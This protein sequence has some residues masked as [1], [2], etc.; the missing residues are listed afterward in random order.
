MIA[1]CNSNSI[2]DDT[3]TSTGI[4]FNDILI[5]ELERRGAREGQPLTVADLHRGMVERLLETRHT[6]P[7]VF[8]ELPSMPIHVALVDNLTMSSIPLMRLPPRRRRCGE[9]DHADVEE[10]D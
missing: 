10:G 5:S 2:D 6:M 4:N 3:P 7:H 9:S 1:T 8:A